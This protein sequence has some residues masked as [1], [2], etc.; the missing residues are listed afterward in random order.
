M[1]TERDTHT[2]REGRER[3]MDNTKDILDAVQQTLSVHRGPFRPSPGSIMSVSTRQSRSPPR[4][5]FI[6][7]ERDFLSSLAYTAGIY[8]RIIHNILFFIYV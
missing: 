1:C 2:H 7:K 5:T 6:H 8:I 3:E 4:N